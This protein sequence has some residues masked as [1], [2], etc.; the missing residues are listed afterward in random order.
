MA[1]TANDRP[2]EDAAPTCRICYDGPEEGRLIK[3]VA[4][5]SYLHTI[6][7]VRRPC[8]CR[9]S[10]AYVHVSCLKRWRK[11]SATAFY[12]C[13][14]CGYEYNFRRTLAY[15]IASNGGCNHHSSA[16]FPNSNSLSAVVATLSTVLFVAMTMISS[17]ITSYFMNSFQQPS[18]SSSWL[19]YYVSPIDVAHDIVAAALRILQD[20]D[21]GKLVFDS[22]RQQKPQ[23]RPGVVLDDIGQAHERPPVSLLRSF[24]SRF[25][26]GLPLIGAGSIVQMLLSLPLLGP[27]QWIARTQANRGR[28]R[29]NNSRDVAA[30]IV[31]GLILIGALRYRLTL[32]LRIPLLNAP[33]RALYK[34]YRLTQDWTRRVLLR[35]EDAILEVS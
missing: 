2:D 9:G 34:T 33:S 14:Q 21:A 7:L 26:L 6:S 11:V 20:D 29:N 10:I 23:Q 32:S 22:V 12:R 27:A 30:L 4:L 31:I 16:R 5:Y 17:S 13:G 18:Y 19:S 28:R 1:D 35:A 15:G 8:K 3:S 25:V 24:L